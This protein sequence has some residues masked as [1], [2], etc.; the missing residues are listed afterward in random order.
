MGEL[1]LFLL[2]WL[3]A[4]SEPSRPLQFSSAFDEGGVGYD[5]DGNPLNS[6]GAEEGNAPSADIGVGYDPNG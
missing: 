4:P 1:I 6:G 5:P 2:L 3:G